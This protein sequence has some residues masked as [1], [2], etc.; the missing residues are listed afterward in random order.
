MER[1]GM[2]VSRW[3][4]GVLE[5][6]ENLDQPDRVRAMIYWGHAVNS[7]TR[8]RDVKRGLDNVELVVQIDPHPGLTAVLGDRRDGVYV[9]PA[10]STMEMAGSGTNSQ[11]AIQWRVKDT[12][13]DVEADTYYEI[14]YHFS[15]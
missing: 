6:P 11:R 9:L 5:D 1:A 15:E 7:Q 2:P 12:Q 8:N 10:G 4:D 14:A 3:F 13:A